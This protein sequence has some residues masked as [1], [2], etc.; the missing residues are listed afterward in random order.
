[1]ASWLNR[2]EA[3]AMARELTA[4]ARP[5][6]GVAPPAPGN[7]LHHLTQLPLFSGMTEGAVRALLADAHLQSVERQTVL[8]HQGEPA[9]RFYVLLDGWVKLHRTAADGSE[10]VIAVIARGESFAEAAL[11]A[12]QRFPVTATAVSDARLRVI[13]GVAFLRRLREDPDLSLNMLA[14]MSRRLRVLVRQLE[15]LATRSALER[16]A[17]FLLQLC[18]EDRSGPACVRL[19]LEK[20]LIAARLGMQPE[21][22]SRALAK[23][24]PIGVTSHGDRV[25]IADRAALR[26]IVDGE[27]TLG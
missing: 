8:F 13:P 11:F 6:A 27:A 26:R 14:S 19:P 4:R 25:E 7:E 3:R 18:A 10:S 15:Q 1:M 20:H 22:F 24:R 12:G 16:L 21:T 17:E 2:A 23:L 9:T 5:Q